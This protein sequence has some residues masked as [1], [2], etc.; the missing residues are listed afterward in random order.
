MVGHVGNN[1]VDCFVRWLSED[2]YFV[3]IIQAGGEDGERLEPGNR[4]WGQAKSTYCNYFVISHNRPHL[5]GL[6][7]LFCQ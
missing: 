7:P 2:C 4:F 3:V 5:F 1:R 6:K